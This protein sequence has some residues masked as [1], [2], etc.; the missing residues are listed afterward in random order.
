MIE[1]G[2]LRKWLLQF[3]AFVAATTFLQRVGLCCLFLATGCMS[4]AV[5]LELRLFSPET[6]MIGQDLASSQPYHDAVSVD[7][8]HL[9]SPSAQPGSAMI[10]IELSG[11]VVHPGVYALD[12][13]Q[14]LSDAVSAAGGFSSSADKLYLSKNINLAAHLSDG[15]FIYIP[16]IGEQAVA[17]SAATLPAS[18]NNPAEQSSGKVNVNTASLDQLETLNGIGAVRAQSIVDNRPFQTTDDLKAKAGIPTNVIS[19]ISSH[20]IF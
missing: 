1:I 16:S 6:T 7:S 19:D 17:Q 3:R 2:D 5:V 4:L 11:A 13:T 10:A 18:A 8:S 9:A 20:I 12:S 15:M 14:R